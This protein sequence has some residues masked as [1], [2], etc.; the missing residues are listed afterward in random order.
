[1]LET[2]SVSSFF[3]ILSIFNMTNSSF[4]VLSEAKR[5]K[6]QHI[7]KLHRVTITLFYSDIIYPLSRSDQEKALSK[8]LYSLSHVH[9]K[10]FYLS[11]YTITSKCI[12]KRLYGLTTSIYTCLLSC[13]RLTLQATVRNSL[14]WSNI[15]SIDKHNFVILIHIYLCHY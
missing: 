11:T 1:M 3:Q 12:L 5:P 10:P 4:E 2:S 15:S 8:P 14:I 7:Q 13:R 6:K 9:F